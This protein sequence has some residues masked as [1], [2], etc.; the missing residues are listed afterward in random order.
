[1]GIVIPDAAD[2]ILLL[3]DGDGIEGALGSEVFGGAEATRTGADD[4]DVTDVESPWKQGTHGHEDE[5]LLHPKDKP[6]GG[7]VD[8]RYGTIS[9]LDAQI[10][11]LLHYTMA[12]PPRDNPPP[13]VRQRTIP[14]HSLA[15]QLHV[16]EF[17]LGFRCEKTY[18]IWVIRLTIA[19]RLIAL[20]LACSY[21][22]TTLFQVFSCSCISCPSTYAKPH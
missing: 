8:R 20:D 21:I 3:E 18:H 6:S 13:R 11:R 7:Q 4:G 16:N 5:L 15:M 9:Q 10:A 14:Y 19:G 1:V 12:T 2:L 22:L 17:T